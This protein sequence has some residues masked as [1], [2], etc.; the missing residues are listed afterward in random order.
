MTKAERQH[1]N[2]VAELGCIV[3]RLK[4]GI[5]DS[6]AQIH[7]I[8]HGQG[9]GQRASHYE[10]IPLCHRHHQGADGIHALGTRE[11]ERHY[12]TEADL[13]AEV[14]RLMKGNP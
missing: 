10:A 13:L 12:G 6:P 8:R 9:M 5:P 1:L 11:W 7:H 4:L 2:A 14:L 3:C